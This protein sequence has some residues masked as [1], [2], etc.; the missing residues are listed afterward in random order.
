[1]VYVCRLRVL[2]LVASLNREIVLDQHGQ[3]SLHFYVLVIH[4]RPR[5]L[6]HPISASNAFAGRS[7]FPDCSQAHFANNNQIPAPLKRLLFLRTLRSRLSSV[8]HPSGP[9]LPATPS[10]D[11]YY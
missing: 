3:H 2:F 6:L 11:H 9:F 7:T 5:F 1:L 4:T 8:T 10:L